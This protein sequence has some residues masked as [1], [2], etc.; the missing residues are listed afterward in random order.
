MKII[1]KDTYVGD[2]GKSSSEWIFTVKTRKMHKTYTFQAK[3]VYEAEHKCSEICKE[4]ENTNR[5]HG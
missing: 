4:L 1:Y 3:N 5:K 2:L